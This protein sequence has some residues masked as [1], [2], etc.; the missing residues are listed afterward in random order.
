[1]TRDPQA[2][3]AVIIVN[4]NGVADTLEVL[5]ELD[6]IDGP[7]L[8]IIVV[9][10]GSSDDSVEVLRRQR[11]NVELVE[12]GE[13]LGFAGGNL[14]GIRL[15]FKQPDIGWVL[16]INN[17]VAVD[18]AFLPPLI[19]ACLDPQVGAA[20]PKIFYFE[21]RDVIW[22]AGGRLR[23]RETVTEEY[24]QGEQDGPEFS[25]ASDMTYLTTCCLLIPRDALEKVGPLDP[26]YFIGVD[27]ADWCRRAVDAGYRL[28]YE[29]RSQIWHKVAVSTGGG[30]TPFKTF[31]TGRSNTL[32]ARRHFR[33]F[34]LSAFLG[35][36]VLALAAAFLREVPR[37]N[38]KAVIAKAKGVWQGLTSTL[39]S[40][41]EI[42]PG[43]ADRLDQDRRSAHD[44]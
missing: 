35:A 18:R 5:R 3:V 15:A 38:S 1:M 36:N 32:Y 28:R 19:E 30:Y 7:P 44:Q 20:S 26:L 8:R 14:A 40:P 2:P 43:G 13:N 9:D 29:P 10:N 12:T 11:P 25:Q 17:D 24:G 33:F 16:L 34:G 21:P 27:D 23:L 37:G 42:Q 39:P 22:A 31:H 6:D 41:P 4:W